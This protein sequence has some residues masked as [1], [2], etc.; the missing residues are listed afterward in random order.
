VSGDAL[1]HFDDSQRERGHIYAGELGPVII[2]E[3]ELLPGG[4]GVTRTVEKNNK[5]RVGFGRHI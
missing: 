3:M 1:R 5:K 4:P 2:L